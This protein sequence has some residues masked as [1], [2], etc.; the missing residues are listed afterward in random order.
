MKKICVVSG[1][2][3]EYGQLRW[4]MEQIKSEKKF[5][6]QLVVTGMHLSPEFDLTYK[7]I[8]RDG[9][10]INKKIEILLSSDSPVGIAKSI[11]LGVI[12]FGEAFQE[13]RPDLVILLGDRFEILAAATAAMVARVPIAHLH[14]GEVT[15]GVIDESIRHAITKMASLHFVAAQPYRQRVIQL[16]E[17][18]EKVYVVGGLGVDGIKRLKLLSRKELESRHG[19]KFLKKNLL[20]T[21]H[22]LT[23]D[24]GAS[25][26]QFSNL[27]K[28]LSSLDETRLI[29]TMPNADSEGRILKNM[30]QK[31]IEKNPCACAFGSLGQISYLS[32][33]AQVDGV[34]GNS[35]SGLTEVPS[36]KKGTINIG[37]RQRGRLQACSVIN[38]EAN[39]QSISKALKLLYTEKYQA[40][41]ASVVNPYGGGDA[42]K[43][44]IK[45]LKSID[46]SSLHKKE[47]F[48]LPKNKINL[49]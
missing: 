30:I 26:A 29:F 22:P 21:Y 41:L 10:T 25:A 32:C 7:E 43:A 6:L 24:A 47:F 19:F 1:A 27:L 12:G 13:L 8:K 33:I 46:L 39:T 20:I 3:S 5:L 23:L 38:A 9:F 34:V 40:R 16:G 2:R 36:L 37:N 31:F 18:P 28:A 42:S 15:M 49:F 17:R 48:D 35:S 44:I 11:G 4:L 14:G 45:I